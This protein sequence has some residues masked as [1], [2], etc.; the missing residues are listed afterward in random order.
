[1]HSCAEVG[2]K[3][4]QHPLHLLCSAMSSQLP[5][6]VGVV[7]TAAARPVESTVFRPER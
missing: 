5:G 2:I 7:E 6:I 1:M 3:N 4:P